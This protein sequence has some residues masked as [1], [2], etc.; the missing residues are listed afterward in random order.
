MVVVVIAEHGVRTVVTTTNNLVV[1]FGW[2]LL[3]VTAMITV[4]ATDVVATVEMATV[5]HVAVVIG[6]L[7]TRAIMISSRLRS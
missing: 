1:L 2:C 6:D 3:A 7:H 4:T 5:V